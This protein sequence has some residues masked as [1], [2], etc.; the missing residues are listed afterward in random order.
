MNHTKS[1]HQLNS[2]N[3]P[4]LTVTDPRDNNQG[5]QKGRSPLYLVFFLVELA[6]VFNYIII[7]LFSV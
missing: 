1:F 7:C 2:L 6:T 4:W 3:L 5:V